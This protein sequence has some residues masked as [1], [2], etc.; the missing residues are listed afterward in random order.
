MQCQ[1]CKGRGMI[2]YNEEDYGKCFECIGGVSSCCDVDAIEDTLYDPPVA[3][4]KVTSEKVIITKD[5]NMII[6]NGGEPDASE[7]NYTSLYS[8]R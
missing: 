8:I 3:K 5:E 7:V 1:R 2:W 6:L 4:S